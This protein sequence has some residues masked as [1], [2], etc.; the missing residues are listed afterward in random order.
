MMVSTLKE[1]AAGVEK[2]KEI[3]VR[4]HLQME[5]SLLSCLLA[6]LM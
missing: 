6:R 3:S 1:T 5:V 4:L 2:T